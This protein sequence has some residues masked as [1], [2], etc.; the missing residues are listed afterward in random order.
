[1]VQGIFD[2][3]SFDGFIIPFILRRCLEA[4]TSMKDFPCLEVH[5]SYVVLV[6]LSDAT[7]DKLAEIVWK[8]R[9]M[10]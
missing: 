10:S 9:K 4:A 6:M 1:M 5:T 8:Q 2:A 3:G 7:R